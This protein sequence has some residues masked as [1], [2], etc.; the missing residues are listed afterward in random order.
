MTD[1]TTNHREN[2]QR[3]LGNPAEAS[4]HREA[5]EPGG[6]A[7]RMHETTAG[8]PGGNGGGRERLDDRLGAGPDAARHDALREAGRLGA[9]DAFLVEQDMEDAGERQGD[10]GLDGRPSPLANADNPQR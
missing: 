9:P 3:K 4:D 7:D 5:R 1:E 10:D 2:G 8:E 6:N